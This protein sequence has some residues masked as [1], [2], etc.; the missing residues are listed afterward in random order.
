MFQ[1]KKIAERVGSTSGF[2]SSDDAATIKAFLAAMGNGGGANLPNLPN[3]GLQLGATNLGMQIGAKRPAA[4]LPQSTQSRPVKQ[5][6]SASHY[7]QGT[8]KSYNSAK[9]FG[10]ITAAG[11][12]GDIYF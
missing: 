9:G 10:F 5:L 1:S 6:K 7:S 8:V 12:P 4:G 3:L 11:M 2:K